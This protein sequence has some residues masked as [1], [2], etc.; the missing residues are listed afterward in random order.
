VH[1]AALAAGRPSSASC[2]LLAFLVALPAAFL[3]GCGSTPG[4]SGPAPV[5][6]PP[7]A[8]QGAASAGENA[9]PTKPAQAGQPAWIATI[10]ATVTEV[11]DGDT[12]RAR[13]AG[14]REERV[15]L[16]GVDTPESTT[17]VEP[18]GKEAAAY[19][20]RHL[21]GRTVYLE[22]D[23][24]ERDKYGRLLAYVWLS[25][26][27]SASE[28]EVRAKMFNAELLLAGM[29]QVMTVPPNVKYADLFVKLQREAREAGKGLW[30]AGAASSSGTGAAAVPAR[31]IGNA[32][33]RKFH[34]P[35][36]EWAARIAPHNRVEFATREAAIGAGYV[37]CKV[38]RP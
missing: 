8:E 37:P 11:I 24:G 7:T 30:A 31:Y 3:V 26:P 32:N 34:R 12:F 9:Q 28:A 20:A 27:Q 18:Y 15:R 35:D 10:T 17:Q 1:D 22:L 33:S 14:G 23:V 6:A 38:C 4:S 2:L 21:S 13:L 16:I 5:Q 29:A 36:C 19:T 25:P